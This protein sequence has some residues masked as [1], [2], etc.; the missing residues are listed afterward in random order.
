MH[1][2]PV[3]ERAQRRIATGFGILALLSILFL[4]GI[5]PMAHT[6]DGWH[7]AGAR[8]STSGFAS[9]STAVETPNPHASCPACAFLRSLLAGEVGPTHSPAR[10]TAIQAAPLQ[11]HRPFR[12]RP[13]EAP[14]PRAP[15]V[16]L[17]T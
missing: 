5:L 12:T 14:R 16:T 17:H 9:I 1:K 4:P 8:S 15:P 10:E 13:L 7:P 2:G 11:A 6:C 3:R